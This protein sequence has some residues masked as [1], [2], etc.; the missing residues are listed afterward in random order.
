MVPRR[1]LCALCRR[2]PEPPRLYGA[3]CNARISPAQA[4]T[5]L[6]FTWP[7]IWTPH[8][9]LP[10][11][12]AIRR[13][14]WFSKVRREVHWARPLELGCFPTGATQRKKKFHFQNFQN[15]LA[16]PF[17]PALHWA[18]TTNPPFSP[19]TA[20][21]AHSLSRFCTL[22][23]LLL[24]LNLLPQPFHKFPNFRFAPSA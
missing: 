8:F 14:F 5:A 1:V 4:C 19:A 16:F 20:P 23:N 13:H 11:L 17:P 21:A 15:F 12:H 3:L 7:T 10:Q 24:L 9:H 6:L 22:L 2:A 18:R